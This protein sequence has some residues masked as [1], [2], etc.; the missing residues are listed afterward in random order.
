MQE[1]LSHNMAIEA[2]KMEVD[3]LEAEKNRLVGEVRALSI[4][5]TNLE[6][7]RKEVEFQNKQ[8]EG[9]KAAETLADERALKAM[10]IAENL[11]KEVDAKKESSVAL[12]A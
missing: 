12:K 5:R 4:A 3:T 9:A 7:L 6:N 11:H 1:V 8:V 10:E 2:M